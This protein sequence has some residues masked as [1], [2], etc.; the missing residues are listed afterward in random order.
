[1]IRF[2][3]LLLISTPIASAVSSVVNNGLDDTVL[4]NYG[5][6]TALI[7]WLLKENKEGRKVYTELLEKATVT[8]ERCT[9]ALERCTGV[10]SRLETAIIKC[11]KKD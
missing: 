6:C 4:T 10:L 8:N 11:E 9:G 7:I 3:S 2:H 5:I 1:M